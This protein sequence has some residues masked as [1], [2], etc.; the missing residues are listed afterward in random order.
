MKKRGLF[1][2][3]YLMWLENTDWKEGDE[4]KE[5]DRVAGIMGGDFSPEGSWTR[6]GKPS[7]MSWYEAK[8]ILDGVFSSLGI[9]YG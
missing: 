7:P 1:L 8:G 5:G 9:L 2:N 4:L 3:M 6:S